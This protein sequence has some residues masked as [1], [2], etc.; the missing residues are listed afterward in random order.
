LLALQP[1]VHPLLL[2]FKWQFEGSR[3]T[4]RIDKVRL[5]FPIRIVRSPAT[6][7]NFCLCS[8]NQPEY[9]LSFVLNLLTAHERFLGEDIQYLLDTNG[10]EH[11]DA[12]VSLCFPRD[13]LRH[14]C[15][16]K[17]KPSG[18]LRLRTSSPRCCSRRWFLACGITSRNSCRCRPSWRTPS[19]KWSSLISNFARGGTSRGLG[20]LCSGRT[21]KCRKK[22]KEA[23]GKG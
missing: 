5:L 15:W 11:I 18:L 10:F 6:F 22:K 20:R 1:L 9:P 16:L 7:A 19:T 3:G 2:R 23:S 14:T 4:N 17:L 13:P 8:V 12:V 21:S